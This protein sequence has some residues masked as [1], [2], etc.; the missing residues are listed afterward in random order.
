MLRTTL[1]RKLPKPLYRSSM[2]AGWQNVEDIIDAMKKQHTMNLA[3]AQKI[4]RHFD[5][6]SERQT[7]QNIF[8]FLKREIEYRVEPADRQTTKSLPRFLADGYGDCK[9]FSSFTN[10]IMCCLGYRPVYRFAGYRG[11]SLTHVYCILPQSN[12]IVD[13]VLPYFDTEKKF[14]AKK[15]IDMSLYRLSGIPGQY[16]AATS[17]DAVAGVNFSKIKSGVQRAAAKSS[18]AVK[19]A[20]ASVPA[21]AKN[22]ASTTATATLAIPR[23][24]FLGLVKLNFSG[25]AT[26]MS[27]ILAS[28]GASAFSWW[29]DLGGDIDSIQKAIQVGS[30]KKRIAGPMEESESFR[31]IFGGYSGSGVYVGEPVTLASAI[32]SATPILIKVKAWMAKNGVDP[33]KVSKAVQ[34]G[35]Q[36]FQ[37]V[38]GKKIEDVVFKKDSGTSNTK[39]TLNAGDLS[40]TSEADARAIATQAVASAAE[41]PKE[42]IKEMTAEAESSGS[43]AAA[44]AP[45]PGS[46]VPAIVTPPVPAKPGID[47]SSMLTTK[48]LLIAAAAVLVFRALK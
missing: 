1:I 40:A 37:Q 23:N 35:K 6:G 4:C 17:Y 11:N 12:T 18:Q 36:T 31:E 43:E 45:S 20:A 2:L 10:T 48:N 7:A 39:M 8:D 29:K 16:D 34:T 13:A 41:V 47:F 26:D 15:D 42:V 3:D 14:T 21:L 28:K 38:T 5:G 9:H 19:K 33:A 25:I 44:L 22:I 46:M 27:R 24:A 30:T 32:A